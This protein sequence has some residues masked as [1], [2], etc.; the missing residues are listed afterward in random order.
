MLTRDGSKGSNL[1][2]R[3]TAVNP[4]KEFEFYLEDDGALVNGLNRKIT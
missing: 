3:E 4:L 1:R 2:T